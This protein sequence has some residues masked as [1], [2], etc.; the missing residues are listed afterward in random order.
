MQKIKRL[1]E[2]K[3]S[4]EWLWNRSKEQILN[5][6]DQLKSN[7]FLHRRIRVRIHQI[8]KLEHFMGYYCSV[9]MSV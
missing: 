3:E 4:L 1:T 8:R 5:E 6:E 2:L 9:W 7:A